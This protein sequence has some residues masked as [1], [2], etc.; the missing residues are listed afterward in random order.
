[1]GTVRQP[2]SWVIVSL[3]PTACCSVQYCTGPFI[4]AAGRAGSLLCSALS[5]VFCW[6]SASLPSLHLILSFFHSLVFPSFFLSLLPSLSL[7]LSPPLS[8]LLWAPSQCMLR[9]AEMAKALIGS[10]CG[11][12]VFFW[13]YF[14]S[15]PLSVLF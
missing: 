15:L 14:R 11:R 1:M 6:I 5:D 3:P 8:P 13:Y 10:S 2:G 9:W 4:G 12:S 7:S